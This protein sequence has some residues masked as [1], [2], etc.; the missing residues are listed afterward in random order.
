LSFFLVT[1]C[2]DPGPTLVEVPCRPDQPEPYPDGIPYVGIHA[3]A[4]G[5]DVVSCRS[6]SDFTQVWHALEGLALVQPN[7]FSPDGGVIYATTTNPEPEGCRLH[8]LDASTGEVIWCRTYPGSIVG[9]SVEV[10]SDGYLYFA[11]ETDVH[12]L[13]PDGSD[14]WSTSVGEA[15]GELMSGPLGVHFT[16]DGHIATVTNA[17][18]VSLLDRG[19]GTVLASLDIVETWG[20]VAP[21]A[22]DFDIMEML[23][24]EVQADVEA[25]L[26]PYESGF[27]G[28][29]FGGGGGFSDNTIAVSPRNELYVIGGGPDDQ[30]GALV[31]IVIEG[32]ADE[33]T[34]APGWYVETNQ[35]SAASPSITPDGALVSVGDGSSMQGMLYPE[36]VLPSV[37]LMDIDA[38]DAN[39]DDDPAPEIC[40]PIHTVL[41]ERGP[42]PGSPALAA[43]GTMYIWETSLNLSAYS[44]DAIDVRAET[45]SGQ[46]WGQPLP[47]DMSWTSVMTVTD[48]HIIGTGTR[49]TP[50]EGDI[51][52][53]VLPATAESALLLVDRETGETLWQAPVTDDSSAT[54]TIGPD[55]GLYVGMLGLVSI[56]AVDTHPVLGLI[57]FHPTA[58]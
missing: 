26:G 43:D 24:E 19:D 47:D 50:S 7:T 25:V 1:G 44:A 45:A 14:R 56:L 13:E 40:A 15:V 3:N 2:D 48:N 34:L 11:A 57:K 5:N 32:T 9:S 51:A 53:W 21:A 12:S 38:C 8:A 31:Q 42:M 20:F 49:V 55:G 16:P 52:G 54:V 36:A 39:T 46:V 6:G 41:L 23:P 30:H 17:G 35:G 29:F 58:L 10:D 18:V 22:F 4:E 28:P 37:K 27:F 33:P